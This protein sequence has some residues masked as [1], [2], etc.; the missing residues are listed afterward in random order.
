[1]DKKGERWNMIDQ[2]GEKEA[3]DNTNLLVLIADFF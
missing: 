3:R 2:G 1:M